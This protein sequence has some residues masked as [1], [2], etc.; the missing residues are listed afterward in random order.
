MQNRSETV[1]FGDDVVNMKPR[2]AHDVVVLAWLGL[3]ISTEALCDPKTAKYKAV[4]QQLEG[5][6]DPTQRMPLIFAI[7]VGLAEIG[8]TTVV[9][10]SVWRGKTRR[11]STSRQDCLY[12][13]AITG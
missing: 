11:G 4:S 9:S 13:A 12:S 10:L 1:R 3:R 2:S 5:Q 7:A 8:R 6:R